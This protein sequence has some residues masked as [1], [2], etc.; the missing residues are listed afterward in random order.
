MTSRVADSRDALAA[1]TIR[2]RFFMI[3]TMRG[4]RRRSE[5]AGKEREE[6]RK[7]ESSA[8]EAKEEESAA[9]AQWRRRSTV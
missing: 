2:S 1:G 6:S 8:A 9:Y 7:D 3:K 4:R 5:G